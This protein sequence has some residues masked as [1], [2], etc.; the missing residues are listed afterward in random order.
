MTAVCHNSPEGAPHRHEIPDGTRRLDLSFRVDWGDTDLRAS[1]EKPLVFCSFQCLS[2][3][4]LAKAID[5]D[6]RTLT[7]G[8]IDG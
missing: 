5:H 2:E 6:G 1:H 3:W 4:A 7:E 8:A